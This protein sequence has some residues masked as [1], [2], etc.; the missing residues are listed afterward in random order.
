MASKTHDAQR[1]QARCRFAYHKAAC[2]CAGLR[3]VS[4]PALLA[5]RGVPRTLA[6]RPDTRAPEVFGAPRVRSAS[7]L[8]VLLYAFWRRRSR[9]VSAMRGKRGVPRLPIMPSAALDTPYRTGSAYWMCRHHQD[10]VVIAYECQHWAKSNATRT[11]SAPHGYHAAI[12]AWNTAS[13]GGTSR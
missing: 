2:T 12:G 6:H 9:L 7:P 1:R 4:H 3:V 13:T 10:M 5:P 8:R 11:D